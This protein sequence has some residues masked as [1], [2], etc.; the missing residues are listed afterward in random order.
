MAYSSWN[1]SFW[2]TAEKIS[3]ASHIGKSSLFINPRRGESKT[4]TYDELRAAELDR[5]WVS[6][7][8]PDVP[9]MHLSPLLFFIDAFFTDM[10]RRFPHNGYREPGHAQPMGASN[11]NVHS[12][13]AFDWRGG[14]ITRPT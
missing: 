11:V 9:D 4:F 14:A 12:S 3:G 8:F 1:S 5:Q 13:A 6:V 7:N 2:Y 10:R